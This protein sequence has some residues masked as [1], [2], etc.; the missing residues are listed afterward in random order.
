[1]IITYRKSMHYFKDEK[2]HVFLN[3][4]VFC[5]KSI[6][7]FF[8]TNLEYLLEKSENMKYGSGKDYYF[9]DNYESGLLNA[10]INKQISF[11]IEFNA[12]IHFFELKL[13]YFSEKSILVSKVEKIRVLENI[14]QNLGNILF[15]KET[16][17][18]VFRLI[19]SDVVILESEKFNSNQYLYGIK[20]RDR[21]TFLEF[22]L[23]YERLK[24]NCYQ[25]IEI[26]KIIENRIKL[27]S[28]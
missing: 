14:M 5:T 18:F 27:L 24:K 9:Q 16:V 25:S 8:F 22:Y 19:P 12:L 15:C 6:P 28:F 4:E 11:I 20:I 1:M 10:L 17:P 13:D 2:D 23:E 21:I 7:K 26:K 3:G